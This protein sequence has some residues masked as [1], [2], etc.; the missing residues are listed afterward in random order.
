M[1]Y[2]KHLKKRKNKPYCKLLD[3]EITLSQC[4]E[5]VNKEYRF[6][7]KGKIKN[8][9][10]VKIS[11]KKSTIFVKNG[12]FYTKN[13]Q[14]NQKNVHYLLN[15]SQI[16]NSAESLQ[17]SAKTLQKM[18]NKSNKLAK[19]ERKRKSVFTDNDRCMVCKSTYQLTWNE[20]YRGRN[21]TN[22]MKYGFCLRMCLNCHREYQED[23]NFNELW[24]KTAQRYF[25]EY[26]GTRDEFISIF[27]RNYLE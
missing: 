8:R 4:R 14:N 24:H 10:N 17:S 16:I 22:S 26:Y 21:R 18:K 20:I 13:A 2:C 9:K 15:N 19:L 5:C 1:K 12:T 11:N 27:R 23:A 7:V 6:P 25:E 3:K